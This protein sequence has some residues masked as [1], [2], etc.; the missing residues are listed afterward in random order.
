MMIIQ[1]NFFS[2]KDKNYRTKMR[3]RI[4]EVQDSNVITLLR[5]KSKMTHKKNDIL[6]I[7]D[8]RLYANSNKRKKKRSMSDRQMNKCVNIIE[9]S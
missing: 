7:D 8:L 9:F 5:T 4:S 2:L 1:M 6:T 3:S